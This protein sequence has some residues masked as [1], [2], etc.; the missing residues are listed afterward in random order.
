VRV[1]R[2]E[3]EQGRGE[4]EEV[5]LLQSIGHGWREIGFPGLMY[6]GR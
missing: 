3:E 4:A 1:M 2:E 6:V 5:G